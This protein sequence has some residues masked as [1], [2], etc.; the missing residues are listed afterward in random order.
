MGRTHALAGVASLWMLR[1]VPDALTPD[2]MLPLLTLA[3]FG[4]LVPD[5]D[6]ADSLLRRTSLLGITPLVPLSS[7]LHA[8]FGHRGATH[9]LIGFV[10]AV[11]LALP[12]AF[13]PL[14]LAWGWTA[15]LAFALGYA[16]HLFCDAATKSG[17]PLFY[18]KRR[19]WHL[20]PRPLRLTTG[21]DAEGVPFALFAVLALGLLL[22][23]LSLSFAS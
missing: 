13:A 18:P 9:S 5:L 10:T 19:R 8:N 2:H 21:S 12:L 23:V 15:P 7:L 14:A 3:V 17:I 22:S 16:S 4:A 1:M 11:V 6:A 20:L